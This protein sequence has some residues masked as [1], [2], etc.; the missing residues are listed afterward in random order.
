LWAISISIFC[1]FIEHGDKSE[2]CGGLGGGAELVF[3][4]FGQNRWFHMF[5]NDKFF[6]NF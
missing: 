3:L 2:S 5:L 1:P 4:D 6:R